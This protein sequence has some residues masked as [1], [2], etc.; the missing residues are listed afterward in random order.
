MVNLN[1]EFKTKPLKLLGYFDMSKY[2]SV[3]DTYGCKEFQNEL[4]I[5]LSTI[6][7]QSSEKKGKE[8]KLERKN[9]AL[10]TLKPQPVERQP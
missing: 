6:A 2:L 3:F 10:L 9:P 7:T 4:L 8:K 1:A 5:N